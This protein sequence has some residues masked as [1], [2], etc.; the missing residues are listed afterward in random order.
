VPI[1]GPANAP[2][3]GWWLKFKAESMIKLCRSMIPLN[4]PHYKRLIS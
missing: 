4:R 1:Q 3:M 2:M